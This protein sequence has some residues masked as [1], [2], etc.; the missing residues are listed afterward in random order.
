MKPGV[1]DFQSIAL[2]LH[3]DIREDDGSGVNFTSLPKEKSELFKVRK[4]T[5]KRLY[6]GISQLDGHV[7]LPISGILDVCLGYGRY[8]SESELTYL[9]GEENVTRGEASS[10]LLSGT[11]FSTWVTWPSNHDQFSMF[12]VIGNRDECIF[13]HSSCTPTCSS[14]LKNL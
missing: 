10:N 3:L 14:G 11:S 5:A 8:L 12:D 1:W 9:G 4:G 6:V 13:L 2:R 7:Y